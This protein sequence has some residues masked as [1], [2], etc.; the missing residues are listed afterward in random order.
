MVDVQGGSL[1]HLASGSVGFFCKLFDHMTPSV[2]DDSFW[3]SPVICSNITSD[4][5]LTKVCLFKSSYWRQKTGREL[6]ETPR[7]YWVRNMSYFLNL[8]LKYMAADAWMALVASEDSAPAASRVFAV[9][10]LCSYFYASSLDIR[11]YSCVFFFVVFSYQG[12]SL[13]A[14]ETMKSVLV[15]FSFHCIRTDDNDCMHYL[16]LFL[17]LFLSRF[18]LYFTLHTQLIRIVLYFKLRPF[19][20]HSRIWLFIIW[21]VLLSAGQFCRHSS[22]MRCLFMI[23]G[24][25]SA[26]FW[27]MQFD[28]FVTVHY[29]H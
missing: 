26:S 1:L 7:A 13:W 23:I 9:D 10:M 4:Y 14:M 20:P 6:V 29:I 19:Y 24:M 3:Y 15:L 18:P 22:R 12:P 11:L 28:L 17:A 2:M 25:C 21:I 16:V 27:K 5:R 8:W